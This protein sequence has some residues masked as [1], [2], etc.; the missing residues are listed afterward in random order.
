MSARIGPGGV[1]KTILG[2]QLGMAAIL[3]AAD[4][5]A[6][7]PSLPFGPKPPDMDQPVR[8]GDQTRRYRPDRLPEAPASRP[9]PET[10]EMPDRLH[11]T[12]S[13]IDGESVLRLTGQIA[14]GDADRFVDYL[15]QQDDGVNTLYLHSPGGSV[16]DALEIGRTIRDSGATTAIA[17]GDVCLS[18]CPYVL[19]GGTDRNVD[20]EGHVGVHQ[21]YFGENTVLPAFMAVEDVQRGQGRVM[22]YL[23]EMGIGL[24]VMEPALLT[25]PDEI[26]ML[27][28][29]DLRTYGIVA[30]D[31]RET[32]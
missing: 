6:D 4:I 17:A 12:P 29:E 22:A 16:Q 32:G 31:E 25:P 30:A 2:V 3:F 28:P 13:E 7:M 14:P 23:E 24:G 21:H 18:A 20:P 15:Q 27:L 1:I 8:P 19:F 9:F 5:G 26:Y 10:G 11:F